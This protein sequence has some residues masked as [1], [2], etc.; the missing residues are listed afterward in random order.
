MNFEGRNFIRN[1]WINSE[2]L[3]CGIFLKEFFPSVKTLVASIIAAGKEGN[4]NLQW[5]FLVL[6]E[7]QTQAFMLTQ[8]P[9]SPFRSSLKLFNLPT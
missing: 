5:D 7:P 4:D 2:G 9:G 3:L 8:N 1:R 6:T